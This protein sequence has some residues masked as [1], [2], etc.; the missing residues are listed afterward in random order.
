MLQRLKEENKLTID[1]KAVADGNK[2]TLNGEMQYLDTSSLFHVTS[3]CPNGKTE[4]FSKFQKLNEKE[5]K[6]DS[7]IDISIVFF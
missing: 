1:S 3:A 7:S 6:G 5:Y 4:I 2:Y